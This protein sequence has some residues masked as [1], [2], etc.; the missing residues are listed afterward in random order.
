[1]INVRNKGRSGESEFVN[2]FQPFFPET[3]KRNLLQTREGGADISG[4]SP[5]QIEVKRCEKLEK[6][7]W[8]KQVN[9]ALTDESEI[10]V[11]A[12]RQNKRPWRFLMSVRLVG[13][14]SDGWLEMSEDDWVRLV[15]N[16][17]RAVDQ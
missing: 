17:F 9:R 8:W 5:F 15:I 10:P 2:R 7:K 12:Y 16:Q 13:V 11:V 3:L 4:C 14:D 6:D 1:M